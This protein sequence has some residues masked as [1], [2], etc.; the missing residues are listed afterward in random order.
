MHDHASINRSFR[1][2]WSAVRRCWVAVH[3]RAR[4]HGRGGAARRRSAS[5]SRPQ[6][7]AMTLLG[8]ALAAAHAAPQPDALPS[9]ATLV[10]GQA[11]WQQQGSTLQ[12]TQ[13]SARA[14]I[15]WQ[16]FH[17]GSGA[18]VV[19]RQPDVH[20]V[21]LNR[22]TGAQPSQI[23]GQLSANGQ[24]FLLNPAGVYFSPT[25]SA[26]VGAL[27]AG[28]HAIALDDFMAGRLN[29][30]RNGSTASVVNEG[31]LTA[32][33]GGYI[34]L[35]APEVRNAGVITAR[36]GTVALAAGEVIELQFT[37]GT[38]AALRVSPSELA[39]LVENRQAVLAPDGQIL[40]SA[41]AAE[42][43]AGGVI[44]QDGQAAASSLTARGGRIVL[45]ADQVQLGAGSRTEATG[46]TGGGEIHIGGNAQGQG[47][48]HNARRT[49]VAEG[50]TLDAS[51][52]VQGDGGKV[53]VWADER[54]VFDGHIAA[55]GGAL[56]G[57]GGF[58]ETSGKRLLQ[59][60]TGRVDAGAAAGQG[61]TWLLDPNDLLISNGA[62]TQVSELDGS[63]NAIGTGSVLN[64]AALA[65]ALTDGSHVEV[66]TTTA[67]ANAGTGSITIA[68]DIIAP[69]QAGQTATLTL[70]AHG[71]IVLAH[72]AT[73]AAASSGAALSNRGL[74]LNLFAGKTSDVSG[75]GNL[76]SQDGSLI[77]TGTGHLNIVAADV[78]LNALDV[79]G[80]LNVN[81]NAFVVNSIARV[82]GSSTLNMH[83]GQVST[84]DNSESSLEGPIRISGAG[85][86]DLNL[87]Q[88]AVNIS[89]TDIGDLR[90]N[91]PFS[92]TNATLSNTGSALLIVSAPHLQG[93]NT[94]NL[95][96]LAQGQVQLHG[97][98]VGGDLT[99]AAQ[100]VSAGLDVTQTGALLVGGNSAFNLKNGSLTLLDAG[101]RLSGA[102]S[103]TGT[104]AGSVQLHN[105]VDTVLGGMALGG[106]LSLTTDNK[107]V[108]QTQ[109]IVAQDV[110]IDA[111]SAEVT[112]DHG[113]NRIQGHFGSLGSGAVF[114]RN[115]TDLRLQNIGSAA[116]PAA[117]LLLQVSDSASVFQASD[118]A[119]SVS[120]STVI[121][122]TDAGAARIDIGR[123]ENRFDGPVRLQSGGQIIVRATGNLDLHMSGGADNALA[124]SDGTLTATLD[125]MGTT[126]LEAPAVLASGRASFLSITA[127]TV[128][129]GR[130]ELT[131][132]LALHASTAA[133]QIGPLTVE[134][135]TLSGNGDFTL[136]HEQNS[137]DR[138]SIAGGEGAIRYV[139]AGELTLQ[140][141]GERGGVISVAAMDGDLLLANTLSTRSSAA[142]AITLNAGQVSE[143]GDG[144]G[145]NIQILNGSR[146]L[147][148]TGGRATLY[149]GSV[150]N[151]SGLT[152]LVGSGSGRF[153]Y[154]SDES[155]TAFTAALG[156]GLFAVYRESPTLTGFIPDRTQTYG[157][158]SVNSVDVVS[159][160]GATNG[161]LLAQ[162]YPNG[163]SV[164]VG[165]AL[166]N[167]GHPVVG[168]HT[169]SVGS[170]G[171]AL[172]YTIDASR[173]TTLTV[174]P[175]TIASIG[176]LSADKVY[177]GSTIATLGTADA[178]FSGL[179]A[180]DVLSVTGG[181]ARF[182]DKNAGTGKAVAVSGLG[183]GGA[184]AGNYVLA[185]S[186]ANFGATIT[187]RTLAAITGLAVA[188]KVY[189]ATTAATLNTSGAVLEGVVAGDA[190]G[191]ASASAS[192]ADKNVGSGK[193]VSVLLSLGG[194]DAGNYVLADS[195]ASLTASITPRALG[196]VSG[197]AAAG[198]VYDATTAVTLNTSAA[199]FSGVLAGDVVNVS[200]ASGSFADKNVGTDKTVNVALSVG[201]ADAGN[202]LLPSGLA[203]TAS[204]T[205]ASI[206]IGGLS[207]QTKVY[208]ATTA[209]TLDLSQA[210][211]RGAVAGDVL[212]LA[213]GSGVFADKN[214]G[215]GKA[216]RVS[217]LRLGGADAGNYLLATTTG[218]AAAD[219]TPATLSRVTGI[220]AAD[221]LED[222]TATAVLRTG[223]AAFIGILSGDD[224]R[225]AEAQGRFDDA[226][227]GAAK[228]VQI[229][230]IRLGGADAGNY[231]LADDSALAQA[232][233]AAAQA[234][235]AALPVT[236]SSLLRPRSPF[237][238]G[239]APLGGGE[240]LQVPADAEG[241]IAGAP[242]VLEADRI[243]MARAPGSV[244]VAQRLTRL[245]TADEQRLGLRLQLPAS[246]REAILGS[247]QAA[248]LRVPQGSDC[249]TVDA[250]TAELVVEPGLH[251]DT[252]GITLE[253]RVGGQLA[254][255]TL[256]RG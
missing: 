249:C 158:N 226:R 87:H 97:L 24:V 94:G 152:A 243:A 256:L 88:D 248:R 52:T 214:V 190:V 224:L 126:V 111:G 91:A 169:Q 202:Y 93:S 31:R 242:Q 104:G 127:G 154:G 209:A 178:V 187:P 220:V 75:T 159:L 175:A 155:S 25:A 55:R 197:I 203:V 66:L 160:T 138:L 137:A 51:A 39:A 37:N 83:G 33:D 200:T 219:I 129:L 143:A 236:L 141:T 43:L 84:P 92:P 142:D 15:D 42:A 153:R 177:D 179:V 204:I 112:L 149:T 157:D 21:A 250:Q 105:T 207:A 123:N 254:L 14:A 13:G 62:S 100:A 23:F 65:A 205:P 211:L 106:D 48:L 22:V 189:D 72:N 90:L 144:G 122:G 41:R 16:S 180:G 107:P 135:L 96:L 5:A 27:V 252:G 166:S 238:T 47:P 134:R 245:L 10:A 86:V 8:A 95:S 146:L 163:L 229:S 70:Q 164:A 117:S 119:L 168:T 4:G 116:A 161:D 53:I 132:D 251:L 59:V 73:I 213:G 185:D 194:A 171:E 201:G 38:L 2:V 253:I 176:G 18:S 162:I 109:A 184:D 63:F 233:I 78:N 228:R 6:L 30:S 120:G 69:L 222:G 218:Q 156:E 74:N 89:L 131:N 17:I 29:F 151:S 221:K 103:A 28:T 7:F 49:T 239:P 99:V 68:S 1:L 174:T 11:S 247:G 210:V 212:A 98:Q 110:T 57:K 246:L 64:A 101:N 225:V 85:A 215:T 114:V 108:R 145:G 113:D 35:L 102:I 3:E 136:T 255:I 237:S 40:M 181:S 172:G 188:D 217:G 198:K 26:N 50:A 231:Q 118:S 58:V 232:T 227:P 36:A 230:G 139:N 61:G 216:V 183:L 20:S 148:G 128:E 46:A 32:A 244:P 173:S 82:L 241:L 150:A 60:N 195:S 182:A 81:A 125:G 19:F 235:I 56:G 54:T 130:V 124:Q 167:A 76:R 206:S 199:A 44:R 240:A 133:T 191:V 223:Q 34:A 71:D 186:S 193:A 234:D 170:A 147:T 9:G 192:F 115:S 12:I 208:D 45:E 140:S 77:N 80:S 121:I 165:G 196:T 67:G 79:G